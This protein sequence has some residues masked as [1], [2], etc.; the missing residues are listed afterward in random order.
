[1]KKS[2]RKPDWAAVMIAA[3]LIL[4][5][6]LEAL[7]RNH[8]LGGFIYAFEHPGLFLFNALLVLDTL[9][10]SFLFRR[11]VFAFCLLCVIWLTAGVTNCIMVSMRTLPF[12]IIDITLLKDA[13]GLFDV[14]FSLPQRILIIAVAVIVAALIGLLFFKAPKGKRLPMKRFIAGA[15]VLASLTVGCVNLGMNTSAINPSLGTLTD[16]YQ[17]YGFPYCFLVTF[18]DV[19]V[20]KPENYSE[21]AIE[22]V[23][24]QIES[25]QQEESAFLVRPNIVFVQLESFFDPKHIIGLDVTEDP[26]PTFTQL[27][28]DYPSGYLTMPSIGGG[29][30]NS[31]FEV[32]TGM[33]LSHFGAGEYPYNTVLKEKAVESICYNLDPLNY[34]SHAV[35]NHTGSFYSRNLVYPNMGFDTFTSLEYMHDYEINP[36]GWANDSILTGEIMNA[37]KSTDGNDFVFCVTVQSHGHYPTEQVLDDTMIEEYQAETASYWGLDYYMQEI[38]K[39]DDFIAELI[40]ALE[41]SSEPTVLVLYGDH[42]PSLGLT[43]ED[44]EN[45]SLYQ[46]EYVIWNNYTGFLQHIADRDLYAYQLSAY[47]TDLLKIRSGEITRLHQSYLENAAPDYDEYM[48]DLQLL[49]YDVLYGENALHDGKEPYRASHMRMGVSPLGMTAMDISDGALIVRGTGFTDSSEVFFDDEQI[50]TI[51]V[52]SALLVATE[53]PEDGIRVSVGQVTSDHAILSNSNSMIYRENTDE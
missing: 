4:T 3:P 38:A 42:L 45:G 47:V 16:A 23:E 18:V 35:H 12:T 32:L 24:E 36:L 15:L 44:L 31:E 40:A 53:L 11:R 10:I 13:I 52:S 17:N 2:I 50:H 51:Y 5:L 46:T 43:D 20:E 26:I 34:T 48:N 30:A 41:E 1:M 21:K 29:T 49:E 27:K 6:I 19:G 39:V 33:T 9:F 7:N 37:I 25:V 14:Y 28:K 8:P 22:E